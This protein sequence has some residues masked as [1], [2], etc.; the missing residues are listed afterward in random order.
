MVAQGLMLP[1]QMQIDLCSNGL[2]AIEAIKSKHYD[3]VFMDHKMPGMDGIEATGLIRGL[4]GDYYKKLPIIAL[5]ANVI[6]GQKEMFLRNGINDFL[7][8]PIDIKRLNEMLEKWLPSEKRTYTV[9]VQHFGEGKIDFPSIYGVDIPLGLQNCG[10]NLPVFLNILEDF[11]KDAEARLLQIAGAFSGK[12]TRTYVTLVHALK[13]AALSIGA[14]ET[15]EKA[16][17]LEKTAESTDLTLLKSKTDELNENVQTLIGN[18]RLSVDQAKVTV[19]RE[20]VDINT[21]Q[22][23]ILKTALAEMDIEAVNRLLLT[24]AEMSLDDKTK[25]LVAELEQHILMFDY[26]KAIEKIEELF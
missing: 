16:F 9:Q 22:L 25:T 3:L 19:K 21:H 15:G 7:A 14:M 5:T 26:E 4:G 10:G 18:I 13:G 23:E 2:D 6:S 1:Y 12:D 8:K 24:F 20:R 17:W 11:C